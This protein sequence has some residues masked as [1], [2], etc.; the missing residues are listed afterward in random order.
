MQRSVSQSWRSKREENQQQ[1]RIATARVAAK[2]KH[3]R[4]VA[5]KIVVSTATYDISRWRR[6]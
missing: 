6:E 1:W 5:K 2:T 3:Q 4:N